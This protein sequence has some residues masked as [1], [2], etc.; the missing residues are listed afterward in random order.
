[1][2]YSEVEAVVNPLRSAGD[3]QLSVG[4]NGPE[5]LVQSRIFVGRLD[6]HDIVTVKHPDG[7]GNPIAIL[8]KEAFFHSNG[9]IQ[10]DSEII[11]FSDYAEGYVSLQNTAGRHAEASKSQASFGRVP[12]ERSLTHSNTNW[13]AVEKS[14]SP[15]DKGI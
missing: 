13:R 5:E 15:C 4:Q 8:C 11:F 3:P 14:F 6:V 2:E 7:P 12:P 10:S 1:M 9:M